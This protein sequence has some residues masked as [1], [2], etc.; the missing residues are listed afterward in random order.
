[1]SSLKNKSLSN[2][3]C[4][5][6]VDFNIENGELRDYQRGAKQI[7]WRIK[8]ILPTIR[9]L[10]ERGA[11]MV[12]LSHRGRPKK[13]SG[14]KHQASSH[15]LKPFV[16]ILSKLL[17]RPVRFVNFARGTDDV[18]KLTPIL[19]TSSVVLLENLRFYP[20]EEKNGK[21]FAKKLAGW[22]DFY[23]ND[24]FSV[25]HRKSA[26]VS[27]IT[28]FL[29]SYAGLS[30]EN[31]LKNLD[32][33]MKKPKKPLIIILGGAKIS[34]KIGVIKNFLKNVK[35]QKSKVNCILTGGGVAN[36]FFA[37][38]KLPI[39][40]S[41]CEKKV[42]RAASNLLT[43]GANKLL[44]PADTV[45][46]Q[47]KILDIGA[48]T[49]ETYVGIIKKAG[50]VIWSGPMGYIENPKFANGSKAIAEAIIKSRAFAVVGGGETASIFQAANSKFQIPRLH[51]RFGGQANS[52]HIF[53]ST[54]GG[55]MLEFLSG[56]KLPGIIALDKSKKM[57]QRS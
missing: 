3:T 28:K 9:F 4:L 21:K 6:R 34:D 40:K 17:K 38:Q 45:V 16:K 22:G 14:V 8:R 5:L 26:S 39:G 32:K 15:S 25:S 27:A 24:A 57:L 33:V 29:P 19:K 44:L 52:K 41:L 10:T 13:A 42:I 1:L 47:K 49:I 7:P 35:G 43:S 31:E 54:G 20:A 12:I 37:A 48:K 56:K 18:P 51:R 50:T 30:L 46:Y 23:V 55:A 36:T 2:Q 11:R 53:T